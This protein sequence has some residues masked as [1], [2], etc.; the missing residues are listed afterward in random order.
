MTIT[1]D[2]IEACYG[3]PVRRRPIWIMRQ[4]G[5]YQATYRAVRV[6]YS[7]E[8]V[9]TIPEVA[10]EVTLQP[11]TDFDLDAAIIFSDIMVVFPPMG[12]PV[13]FG[14][15]GPKIA[16]PIRS[17]ADVASLAKLDPSSSLRF[18]TDAIRLTRQGLPESVPLIGFSGA[19]FT[20]ACYAIEGATSREFAVAREFFYREPQAA[21]KLMSHLADGVAEYL[22]AQIDAGA[23]AV[24]LFDSW[25]GVLSPEDYRNWILPHM[26]SIVRKVRRP[27]APVIVYVNGS[28]HL[29][30][31][32]RDIPCDVLSVD[33]RTQLPMAAARCPTQTA[34]QGN[35]DPIALMASVEEIEKRARTIMSQMDASGMGHVFNLGHGIMPTTPE[36]NVHALVHAVHSR[37]PKGV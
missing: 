17:A 30:E 19:P 24:Q 7:F 14:D 27:N 36:A 23:D 16:R 25:G 28:S 20:L 8:Q 35:L 6:K 5:R 31:V 26:Q 2:F 10:C 1:R 12:I 11:I 22:N 13:H 32:L 29:I 33:W 4:A 15:G 21:Q 37:P 9:C 34:L 18:V 3:R